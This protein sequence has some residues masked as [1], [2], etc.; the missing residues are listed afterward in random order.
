MSCERLSVWVRYGISA[1]P[2]PD[3]NKTATHTHP[4]SHTTHN[5]TSQQPQNQSRPLAADWR[6]LVFSEIQKELPA[7]VRAAFRVFDS[8]DNSFIDPAEFKRTLQV[9]EQRG[10][11]LGSGALVRPPHC[12]KAKIDLVR[13]HV[14]SRH[15]HTHYTHTQPI[16]NNQTHTEPGVHGGGAAGADGRG[17]RVPLLHHRPGCVRACVPSVFR[18]LP[19]FCFSRIGLI[20][21]LGVCGGADPV[22]GFVLTYLRLNPPTTQTKTQQ[23]SSSKRLQRHDRLQGVRGPVLGRGPLRQ[24]HRGG[25]CPLLAR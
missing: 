7:A 21:F 1:G 9:S 25:L 5:T 22:G 14:A 8:D 6:K 23:K 12:L 2:Q 10:F 4:L 11:E 19:P 3:P 13:L 24:R 15:Q 18:R 20:G 16:K 17:D